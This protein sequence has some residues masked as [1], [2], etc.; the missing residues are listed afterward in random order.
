MSKTIT[1]VG[2]RC[3]GKSYTLKHLLMHELHKFSRVYCCCPTESSNHFCS[4]NITIDLHAIATDTTYTT[5]VGRMIG[6][7]SFRVSG[8]VISTLSSYNKNEKH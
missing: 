3:S 5:A 2:K 7:F 1:L 8:D 4:D 6:V